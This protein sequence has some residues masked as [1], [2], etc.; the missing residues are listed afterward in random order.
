MANDVPFHLAFNMT[1][2]EIDEVRR[3]MNERDFDAWLKEYR[4]VQA[5]VVFG[6]DYEVDK[7]GNPIEQGIGSVKQQ[8]IN[9]KRALAKTT[10]V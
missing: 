10:T 7:N 2:E 1:A 3:R 4:A 6:H 9:H 5:R 8:T